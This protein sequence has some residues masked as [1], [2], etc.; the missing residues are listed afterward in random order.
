MQRFLMHVPPE[1][2]CNLQIAVQNVSTHVLLVG[3]LRVVVVVVVV[4]VLI[5]A[6]ASF[7]I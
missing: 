6:V 4:V 2:S 1:S 3:G 5:P 7:S